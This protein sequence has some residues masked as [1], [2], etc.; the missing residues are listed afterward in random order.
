MS[1][2]LEIGSEARQMRGIEFNSGGRFGRQSS[3]FYEPPCFCNR[4]EIVNLGLAWPWASD[5]E[6]LKRLTV[7]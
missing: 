2:F 7:A 6:T 5:V 3:P 1:K 4:P